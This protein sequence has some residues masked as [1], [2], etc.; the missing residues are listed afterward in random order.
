MYV[1]VNKRNIQRE[2][3]NIHQLDIVNTFCVIKAM[4]TLHQIIFSYRQTLPQVP[5]VLP[6]SI[7]LVIYHLFRTKNCA[8]SCYCP[9]CNCQ[10]SNTKDNIGKMTEIHYCINVF[11]LLTFTC[12][13]WHLKKMAPITFPDMKWSITAH[14][15]QMFIERKKTLTGRF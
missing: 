5:L 11:E 15:N 12:P 14:G 2:K 4:T 3:I 1:T 8:Y 10:K 13:L 6:K 9:S 7:H